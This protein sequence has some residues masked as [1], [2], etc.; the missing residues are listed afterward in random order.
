MICPN[1]KNEIEDGSIF[2]RKCGSKLPEA[3][4]VQSTE[5]TTR[6]ATG[7]ITAEYSNATINL[8]GAA[9]TP[10]K[11]KSTNPLLKPCRICG[12]LISCNA[13]ACPHCGEPDNRVKPERKVYTGTWVFNFILCLLGS[14]LGFSY[15]SSESAILIKLVGYALMICSLIF[16]FKVDKSEPDAAK[17]AKRGSL[18]GLGIGIA[19]VIINNLNIFAAMYTSMSTSSYY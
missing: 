9:P 2:C 3:E 18:V 15:Q 17:Y 1:C 19:L 12:E 6:Q 13:D 14:G 7:E 4:R 11:P 10:I 16:D 8:Q 5:A